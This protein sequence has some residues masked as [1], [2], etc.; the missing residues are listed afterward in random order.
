MGEDGKIEQL[1]RGLRHQPREEQHRRREEER[2]RVGDRRMAAEVIR[3]P[4]RQ[5]A[6]R[7][8]RREV[9]QHGIKVV[10]GIPRDHRPGEWPCGG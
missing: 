4:E 5:I 3:I 8:G 2:L 6:V 10:L 9:A 1:H 7:Q